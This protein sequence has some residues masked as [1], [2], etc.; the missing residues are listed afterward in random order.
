M[1]LVCDIEEVEVVLL[2]L[3]KSHYS[4]YYMLLSVILTVSL[5]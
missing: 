3:L 1:F 2:S 4:V 5:S